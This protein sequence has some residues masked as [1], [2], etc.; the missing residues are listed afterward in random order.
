MAAS[1]SARVFH[2]YS[3]GRALSINFMVASEEMVCSKAACTSGASHCTRAWWW[4]GAYL[5]D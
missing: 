1:W 5:V 3:W 2:R 4:G